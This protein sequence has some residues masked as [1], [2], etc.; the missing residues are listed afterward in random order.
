MGKKSQPKAPAA[1]D[2]ETIIGQQ[3]EQN[4]LNMEQQAGY[5]RVDTISPYQTTRWNR[6]DDGPQ[7]ELKARTTQPSSPAQPKSNEEKFIESLSKTKIGK[8]LNLPKP[9][10]SSSVSQPADPGRWEQVTELTPELQALFDKQVGM[11]GESFGGDRNYDRYQDMAM[12]M[13]RRHLDPVF[14]RQTESFEQTMANRGLPMGSEAYTEG[15]GDL[16]DAQNKAYM[17]AAFNALDF[18]TRLRSQDFGEA[19]QTEAIDYN[20]L[21]GLLGQVQGQPVTPI[22]VPGVDVMGPYGMQQQALQNN[23]MSQSSAASQNSSNFWNTGAALGA[24]WLMSDRRLKTNIEK[25]GETN[26]GLNWY[27]FDY[28]WGE[29]SEGVMSDEVAHIPGA[30]IE[31]PSGYDM[32]NYAVLS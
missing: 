27:K 14:D 7:P 6:I 9:E 24:A 10:S 13:A 17:D 18:G 8:N 26:G 19:V 1:P 32:V 2:Y 25:V 4:R 12:S 3:G 16:V 5:N 11:A 21:A 30:V 23:Y 31:H 28:V 15:Y 20:Q 22:G 29:H